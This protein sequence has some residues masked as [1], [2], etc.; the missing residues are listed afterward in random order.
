[1]KFNVE[2]FPSGIDNL[3]ILTNLDEP[4]D[5]GCKFLTARDDAGHLLGVAGVNFDKE[6]YP[7]FEHIIVVP[8]YQKGKLAAVLMRK[9][10]DWLKGLGF[11][12]Y[13]SFIY[14]E[15]EIMRKYALKFGFRL[16]KHGTRGDWF[17]K[18]ISA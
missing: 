4:I 13:I 14:R 6:L 17:Y 8:R 16:Y 18:S 11:Y 1:M 7:R 3:A 2:Q 15:K 9:T 5:T 10:E 12:H